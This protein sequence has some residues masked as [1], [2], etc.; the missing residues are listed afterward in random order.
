M[1]NRLSET[2]QASHDSA[3]SERFVHV[4]AVPLI[5]EIAECAEDAEKACRPGL[6]PWILPA[7]SAHSAISVKL[8]AFRQARTVAQ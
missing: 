8:P 2:T 7:S 5:T 6:V 1:T 3:P 4:F